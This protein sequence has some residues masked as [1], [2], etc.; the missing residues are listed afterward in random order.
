MKLDFGEMEWSH[1]SALD[2]YYYGYGDVFPA[3]NVDNY[4]MRASNC[5]FTYTEQYLDEIAGIEVT[6][7]EEGDEGE[8]EDKEAE[9]EKGT[10][11]GSVIG[12]VVCTIVLVV[13]IILIAVVCA[14]KKK[15]AK[16][17]DVSTDSQSD[18]EW[19]RKNIPPDYSQ[20]M[21]Y[22]LRPAYL[23]QVDAPPPPGVSPQQAS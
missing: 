16:I 17:S 15:S 9:E 11:K 18:S 20:K 2:I 10:S 21:A 19:I 13:C 7:Q 12:I 22:E 3:E 4:A 1:V 5:N 6:Y 8:G 23:T 14:C